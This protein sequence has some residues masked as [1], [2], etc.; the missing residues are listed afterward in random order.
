MMKMPPR[1][2]CQEAMRLRH[3][4]HCRGPS[5]PRSS[6]GLDQRRIRAQVMCTDK[7]GPCRYMECYPFGHQER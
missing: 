7:Q 2:H 1:W 4:H 6:H 3:M 5:L